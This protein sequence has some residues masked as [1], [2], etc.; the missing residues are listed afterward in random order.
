MT[1]KENDTDFLARKLFSVM[2]Q[3]PGDV[4]DD[5][6]SRTFDD[7]EA[8]RYLQLVP[9]KGWTQR[10]RRHLFAWRREVK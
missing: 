6:I 3:L 4:R 2:F 9:T 8:S 5:V 1:D 7:E 10:A